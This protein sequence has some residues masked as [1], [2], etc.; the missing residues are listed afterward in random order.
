[1]PKARKRRKASGSRPGKAAAE[2]RQAQYVNTTAAGPATR[3]RRFVSPAVRGPQSLVMPAMVAIGC[4]GLAFVFTV[5]SSEPNHIL[6][7]AMAALLALLWT[8]SVAI[9]VR[10]LLLQRQKS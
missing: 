10:K 2:T 5:F 8:F 1:M 7:G 6:F 9:R 3:N 4:W